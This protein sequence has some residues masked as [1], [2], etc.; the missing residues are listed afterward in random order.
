M[1][2]VGGGVLIEIGDDFRHAM[3]T[4]SE[5]SRP[6]DVGRAVMGIIPEDH[7]E[8][9]TREVMFDALS[10]C[11]HDGKIEIAIGSMFRRDAERPR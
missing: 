10:C 6:A 3:D 1:Q 2:A 9:A 7:V 8:L 11:I 5:R 4:D